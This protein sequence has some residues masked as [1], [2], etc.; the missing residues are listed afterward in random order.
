MARYELPQE[1]AVQAYRFALDPTASQER[2]LASHTG[3]ARKAFNVM[4]D[5]VKKNLDQRA[6]ERSYGIPEGDLTPSQGWSLAALRKTWNRVKHERAP[7]W[8]VNSKEAYNTGL[9]GLARGL[10]AWSKSRGGDRAGAAVGFP[11]FKS[12]HLATRSVRFTTGTIRVEP[13]RHHVTLPVVGTIHTLEST[14]KLA[15]RIEAGTARILSATVRLEGGRW[16]CAFQTIVEGKQQPAC[17]TRS[18]HEVAGVDIGVRDLLVVAAP[19]GTEI[20]RVSAPKPLAAAQARLRG[21]QRRAARQQG[22]WDPEIKRRREPSKRWQRTKAQVGKAHAR[23]SNLRRHELHKATTRLARE[24]Q[25]IVVEDLNVAGMTRAGG[26]HKRGLNRAIGDAG[27]GRLKTMLGYKS[28]WNRTTLVTA[29][30]W[31]PST[32]L[33]SRCGAKTK[34]PLRER[35]YHCRSGCPDIDRDLN[36][37]VNLARLG[38]TITRDGGTR[39]G[40]GSSPAASATAGQ[41]RGATRKTRPANPVG[42]AGGRE[43]STLHD[44][45]PW[46]IRRGLPLRKERL[47]E[48]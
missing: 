21:L 8:Q 32:Q 42:K 10:D 29:E 24:Y 33:C 7:W 30:R 39:T 25:M 31:F 22:P 36:A 40:T 6:A 20:D 1:W 45:T 41:G 44:H 35:T 34:L 48:T 19:D 9:D 27:L 37:A 46:P 47:P 4:L 14:R 15:R 26:A 38:E 5:L 13:D 28:T 16:Y 3:A 43:T 12:K 11:R 23:V 2:A 18:A 17:A